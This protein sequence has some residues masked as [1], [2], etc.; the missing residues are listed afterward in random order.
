ML[1]LGVP[2]KQVDAALTPEDAARRQTLSDRI[3]AFEEER[4]EKPAMAEIVTDGDY[5][6]APNGFGDEIVG[7]PECRIPPDEPGSRSP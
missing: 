2:Q 6:Y 1:S 7:C 3:E 4:P 5:R